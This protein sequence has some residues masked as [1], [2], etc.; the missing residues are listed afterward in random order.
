VSR[1]PGIHRQFGPRQPYNVRMIV[2]EATLDDAPGIARVSV[3]TWRTAY[4][5]IIPDSVL[6]SLS[7]EER[8]ERFRHYLP[9]TRSG[10]FTYVAEDNGAIFGFASGGP[11][12]GAIPQ[13]R[14]ELYAIYVLEEVQGRGIGRMLTR[15]V[16]E[17]LARA[18]LHS[19]VVWVLA[20]NPSRH[21]YESLGGQEVGEQPITIGE[22]TLQEVAYAWADTT[23]LLLR[24]IP[25]PDDT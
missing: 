2:R 18:G 14:G 25:V 7:Y 9:D 16:V 4:R 21:F 10:S 23:P 24:R 22:T 1:F 15:A 20:E 12:R 6:R 3:D 13:Y 8:E 19:M 17:R 11:E 5:G